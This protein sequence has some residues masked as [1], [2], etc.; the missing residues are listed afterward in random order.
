[1]ALHFLSQQA[2]RAKHCAYL[3]P[4]LIKVRVTVVYIYAAMDVQPWNDA[5]VLGFKLISALLGK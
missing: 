2:R 4:C 1:M 3:L 5:A